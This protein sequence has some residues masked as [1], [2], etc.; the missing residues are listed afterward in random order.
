MAIEKLNVSKHIQEGRRVVNLAE[1][2]R[3]LGL[4]PGKQLATSGLG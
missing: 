1:A 3:V 2:L 4:V